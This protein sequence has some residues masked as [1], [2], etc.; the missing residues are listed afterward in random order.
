MLKTVG[1][2]STRYGDQTIISGNLVIGTAGKGI[3]FSA[4][5]NPPGMTSELLDDY[6]E[7]SWTA[8]IADAAS[9]GNVATV[10]TVY[11]NYTKVGNLVTVNLAALDIN[12]TGLTLTNPL[13]IRGLPFVISASPRVQAAGS[14]ILDR[15][16][17]TGVYVNPYAEYNRTYLLLQASS[18][19]AAVQ[20]TPVLVSGVGSTGSDIQALTIT[21]HTTA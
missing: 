9:G 20:D 15:I 8:E 16:G 17:T 18:N 3:D 1:N 6:E 13:H 5:S 10:G 4:G 7:G 11:A 12:V 21:Y 19:N 2:P 14:C